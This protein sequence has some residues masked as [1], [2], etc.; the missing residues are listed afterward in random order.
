M[1]V[2][3]AGLV[4]LCLVGGVQKS[5]IWGKIMMSN[6]QAQYLMTLPKGK[7]LIVAEPAWFIQPLNRLIMQRRP[8]LVLVDAIE[9]ARNPTISLPKFTK[10]Y[11]FT[12]SGKIEQTQNVQKAKDWLERFRVNFCR[13][14]PY[15]CTPQGKS[16]LQEPK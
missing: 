16:N 14:F 13:K 8:G 4:I 7:Y 6:S 12:Y 15:N 11:R 3:A 1:G 5:K 2:L 10:Y 9:Q